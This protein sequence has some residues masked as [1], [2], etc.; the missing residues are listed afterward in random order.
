MKPVTFSF[1]KVL[2]GPQCGFPGGDLVMNWRLKKCDMSG[3]VI[4]FPDRLQKNLSAVEMSTCQELCQ[5]EIVSPINEFLKYM[6]LQL[7]GQR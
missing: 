7:H 1:G 4:I 2:G 5:F 6:K 3:K